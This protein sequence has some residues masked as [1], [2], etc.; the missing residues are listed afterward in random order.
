MH[1]T[2]NQNKIVQ[3]ITYNMNIC[4]SG[5][6]RQARHNYKLQTSWQ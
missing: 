3:K 4:L 6:G 2:K 1:N 5:H